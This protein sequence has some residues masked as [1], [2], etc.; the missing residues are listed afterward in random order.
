MNSSIFWDTLSL[1]KALYPIRQNFS[2]LQLVSDVSKTSICI[3]MNT[4]YDSSSRSINFYH[5]FLNA[6]SCSASQA[7]PPFYGT[8][9]IL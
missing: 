2:N 3:K 1:Y 5:I 7:I 6:N 9:K 4:G 8:Q